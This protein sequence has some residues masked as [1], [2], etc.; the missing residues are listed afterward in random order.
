LSFAIIKEA[1]V[2]FPHMIDLSSER[3]N[4]QENEISQQEWPEDRQIENS[5]Q[6]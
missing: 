6:S 2:V 5:R 3:E 1:V 4:T